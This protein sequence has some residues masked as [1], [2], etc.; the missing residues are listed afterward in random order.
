MIG[1]YNRRVLCKIINV[2]IIYSIGHKANVLTLYNQSKM[3]AKH[4]ASQRKPHIFKHIYTIKMITSY[5]IFIMATLVYLHRKT[6]KN[7]TPV[8]ITIHIIIT[9][10]FL[11][12]T[13]LGI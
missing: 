12:F 8:V 9:A 4:Q 6:G 7:Y 2:K 1:Y 10:I 13:W 5:I 3:N 11:I